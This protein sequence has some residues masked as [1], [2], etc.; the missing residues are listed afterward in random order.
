M[1]FPLLLHENREKAEVFHNIRNP[2]YPLWASYTQTLTHIFKLTVLWLFIV[3]QSSSSVLQAYCILLYIAE[4]VIRRVKRVF[5][6]WV[7][8][9]ECVSPNCDGGIIE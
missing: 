9:I 5:A 2:I 8:V 1:G 3:V 6:F 4:S 7:S